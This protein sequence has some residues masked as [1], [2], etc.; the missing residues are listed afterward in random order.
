MEPTKSPT[1]RAVRREELPNLLALYRHLHPNDPELAVSPDMERLWTRI[2]ADPNQHYFGVDVGGQLVATCTLAIIP[3]LTRS[4]RPYG[5]IKNVVTHPDFRR[6]GIGTALLRQAL[7]CAWTQNCY[8]VMLLT[9][10][11]DPATLRF[12]ERAGFRAGVKTGFIAT[13]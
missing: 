5:L 8:K 3:N 10:R 11:K 4:A 13:Q 9:G 6:Q 2:C 7:R 1:I 12:Y